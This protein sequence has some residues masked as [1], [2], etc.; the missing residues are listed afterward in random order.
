MP[1]SRNQKL[2]LLHLKRILE[3]YTDEDH[4]ITTQEIRDHLKQQQIEVERKT[5]YEDI[6]ALEDFGMDIWHGEY[7]KTYRLSSRLFSLPEIK[8]MIDSIQAS[9]F[10]NEKSTQDLIDKLKTLCSHHEARTLE[11]EVIVANRVKTMNHSIHYNVDGI[12]R[13][14]L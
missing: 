13:A 6:H 3:Y 10:L 7:E 14:V 5:V 2:K 1:K 12:H 9:K 8:M 4:G 11:R